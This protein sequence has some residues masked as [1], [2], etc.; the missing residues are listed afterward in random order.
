[1]DGFDQ[2]KEAGKREEG[3]EVLGR[4]LA[5]QGDALEPFDLADTL[6]GATAVRF[7]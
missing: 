2:D 6:L 1:V 4:L 3:G 5:A 7:S